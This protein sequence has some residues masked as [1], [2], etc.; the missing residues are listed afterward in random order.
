MVSVYYVISLFERNRN[1]GDPTGIKL[2]LQSSKEI[3]KETDKIDISVSNAKYIMYHFLSLA[4]KYGWGRLAFMVNT[5][6]GA[7]NLFRLVEEI[8]LE[9]IYKKSQGY[10]ELQG[11]GNVNQV[12]ANLFA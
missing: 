6:T 9:D 7:K 12:L 3:Y 1:P 8:L 2:Y 4:Q 5:G 11:I 10:F